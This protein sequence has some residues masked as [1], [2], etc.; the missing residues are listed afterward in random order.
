M[1]LNISFISNIWQSRWT[2]AGSVTN[3]SCNSKRTQGDTRED[4]F[5]TYPWEL[6]H[7]HTNVGRFGTWTD[8]VHNMPTCSQMDARIDRLALTIV[9][10]NWG[11]CGKKVWEWKVTAGD[12]EVA[13]YICSRP[14]NPR[15]EADVTKKLSVRIS[16]SVRGSW[17]RD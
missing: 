17:C 1:G 7:S 16:P 15:D 11:P 4:D 14:C 5:H 12:C 8:S 9:G 6:T 2:L 10:S 3:F 13:V